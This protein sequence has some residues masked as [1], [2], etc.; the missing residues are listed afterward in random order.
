MSQGYPDRAPRA[1]SDNPAQR[2]RPPDIDEVTLPPADPYRVEHELDPEDPAHARVDPQVLRDGGPTST[3][4][5]PT[6]TGG[7]AGPASARRIARRGRTVAPT[8]TGSAGTGKL[9]STARGHT[10]DASAPT[11][12]AGVVIDDWT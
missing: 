8:T 7:T 4:G 9:S 2:D 3:P 6:T 12:A 5:A 11:S 1:A 10:S